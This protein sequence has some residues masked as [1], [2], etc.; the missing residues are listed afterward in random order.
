MGSLP[1]QRGITAG[2]LFVELDAQPGTLRQREAVSLQLKLP[3]KQVLGKVGHLPVVFQNGEVVD[4]RAEVHGRGQADGSLWGVGDDVEVVS[5][6]HGSH[7]AGSRKAAHVADVQA[8]IVGQPAFDEGG[9]GVDPRKL[10]SDGKGHGRHCPESRVGIRALGPD[11]FFQKHEIH[12]PD[13]LAESGRLGHVEAVVVVD[14][15]SDVGSHSLSGLPDLIGR[16]IDG[17]P[18]FEGAVPVLAEVGISGLGGEADGFPASP[19][20]VLGLIGVAVAGPGRAVDEAGDLLAGGSPQ[21]LPDGRVQ[22]LSQDVPKGDVDGGGG[23]G[24]DG[25]AF[26]VLSAVHLLVDVFDAARVLPDQKVAHVLDGPGHGLLAG[27]GASL[28]DAVDA[29][30]GFDFDDQQVF[31]LDTHEI[32]LDVGNLHACSFRVG[33]AEAMGVLTAPECSSR[34]WRAGAFII[35]Q[36]RFQ[37]KQGLEPGSI[38]HRPGR[39]AENA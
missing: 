38:G 10:F 32:G 11:G 4:G 34:A 33:A 15:Q 25:S 39:L 28:S 20:Q 36:E 13:A 30:V 22:V 24:N 12:V 1:G 23:G 14:G 7:L 21:Q 9:K 17:L 6:G 37:G 3:G 5:L 8:N 29:L 19:D 18:G 31:A 16:P 35:G 27:G 2:S 26:I